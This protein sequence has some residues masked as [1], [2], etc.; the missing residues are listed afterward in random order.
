MVSGDTSEREECWLGV[1]DEVDV[2]MHGGGVV[3]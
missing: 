2:E 1:D 3:E